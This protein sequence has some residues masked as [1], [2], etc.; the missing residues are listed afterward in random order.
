MAVLGIVAVCEHACIVQ[1]KYAD[2]E[3]SFCDDNFFLFSVS[4]ILS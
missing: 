2:M 3:L 1:P 4:S